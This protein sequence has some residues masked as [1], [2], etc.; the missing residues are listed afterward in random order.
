MEIAVTESR[1]KSAVQEQALTA[2]KRP[3]PKKGGPGKSFIPY[4]FVSPYLLVSSTFFFYPLINAVILAFFQTNGPKSKAFVGLGNFTFILSDPD[5]HKALLN[6]TI[7]TAF[8]VCFQLPVSLGLALLLNS[9]KSKIKALFRL[10]IFSPHLVGAV[11]VG[12][13][14]SV[15]FTPRFGMINRFLYDL[16]G[17][18]LEQRWLSNPSMVMPALV[19][20]SLW[21]YAGF[22]MIYFLAALQNVDQNL[23]DASRVDGANAWQSF[24]HVTL[25]AI[26]PVMTFVLVMSIIGSYQLFE[27]PLTL[28]GDGRGPDN[29]GYTIMAY[30][31]DKA[32]M[33]GNLGMGSAVGWILTLIIF[34]VTMIQLRVTKAAE[35]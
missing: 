11:F 26:K 3:K 33:A 13:L 30:L 18:G 32:F 25:P 19:I 29:A 16:T 9:A 12:I 7:Y 8:A 1:T 4:L 6:T 14:F 5:F 23:I 2:K 31:Y 34:T 24:R 15:L 20:T 22:N 27:L 17:W 10:I 35:D 21:M 28:L